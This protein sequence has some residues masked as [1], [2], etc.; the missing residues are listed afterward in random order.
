MIIT[1][2]IL[3]MLSVMVL[4]MVMPI[5]FR[6]DL[7]DKWF[8]GARNVFPISIY[9]IVGKSAF[10]W[11]YRVILILTLLAFI[12]ADIILFKAYI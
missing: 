9:T 4:S 5:A 2:H 12:A 10:I 3:F 6:K 1:I 7:E 8:K 11:I